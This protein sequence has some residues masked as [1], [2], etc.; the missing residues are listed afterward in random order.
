MYSLKEL[1]L[2]MPDLGCKQPRVGLDLHIKLQI[3]CSYAHF[4]RNKEIQKEQNELIS[5]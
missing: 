1:I 3:S 5:V 2:Y 4:R